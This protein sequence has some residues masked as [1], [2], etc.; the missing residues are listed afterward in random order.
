MDIFLQTRVVN[1]ND[2]FSKKLINDLKEAATCEVNSLCTLPCNRCPYAPD[3]INIEKIR[4]KGLNSYTVKL[5][6]TKDE[7]LLI[8]ITAKSL[9]KWL[10]IND[11]P[12][13][14]PIM[15]DNESQVLKLNRTQNFERPHIKS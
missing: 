12:F 10:Q 8:Y 5:E 13:I 9:D 6:K 2:L 3:R 15:N 7:E 11:L 14:T 4:I 1:F